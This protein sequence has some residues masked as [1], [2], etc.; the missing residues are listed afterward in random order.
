MSHR[1]FKYGLLFGSLI[2]GGV[3]LLTAPNS[4]KETQ[5]DILHKTRDTKQKLIEKK[6][7]LKAI[8]RQLN[9][10]LSTSKKTIP[11]TVYELK[12]DIQ[13]WRSEVQDHIQQLQ[14]YRHSIEE[15]IKE[16]EKVLKY[17]S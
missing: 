13:S 4:G 11:P 17:K 16:L 10:L 15:K 8:Q 5:R 9:E 14:S 7:E 1:S 6:Q 3:A 12:Q 2:S